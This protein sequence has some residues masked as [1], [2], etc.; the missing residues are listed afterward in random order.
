MRLA[1]PEEPPPSTEPPVLTVSL[2]VP[3]LAD[4]EVELAWEQYQAGDWPA[5]KTKSDAQLCLELEGDKP[6][7]F[8]ALLPF[9]MADKFKVTGN[10]VYAIESFIAAHELGCYPTKGVL[11]WLYAGLKE[12]HREQGT[13]SLDAILRLKKGRGSKQIDQAFAEVL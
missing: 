7:S 8:F 6:T 10:P 1:K 3:H 5:I 12:W 2:L 11:A 9:T 4:G 13:R